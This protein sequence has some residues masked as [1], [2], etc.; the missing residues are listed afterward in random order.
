MIF[1][2][3]RFP[4]PITSGAGFFGIMLY[5]LSSTYVILPSGFFFH[6]YIT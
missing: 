4:P 2:E 5:F 1:S 6:S 3:N